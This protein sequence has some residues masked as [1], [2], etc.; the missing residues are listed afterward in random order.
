MHPNH[1]R[2]DELFHADPFAAGAGIELVDW[3]GG[4]SRVRHRP[5][6]EQRNFL[7]GLHGAAMFAS[8]DVALAV[9]SNSWGRIALALTVDTHFLAAPDLDGE[10]VTE[11]RERARTRATASY[12][13]EVSAAQRPVASLHAMVYRRNAWHFGEDAWSDDWRGEH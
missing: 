4:W 9:A 5:R 7:G 1:A 12:T 6:P 8:G 10:L 13:I 2:L 11:A 3:G